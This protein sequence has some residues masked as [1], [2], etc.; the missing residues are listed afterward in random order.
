MLGT[1]RMVWLI[2]VLLSESL[3]ILLEKDVPWELAPIG[4]HPDWRNIRHSAKVTWQADVYI[5]CTNAS[6]EDAAYWKSN[7]EIKVVVVHRG[8]TTHNGLGADLKSIKFKTVLHHARLQL[9]DATPPYVRGSN[10]QC[11]S[12]N[13]SSPSLI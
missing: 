11:K 4:D 12:Y 1:G 7:G 9:P 8:R 6:P 3:D 10:S 13:H 5:Y 2:Y